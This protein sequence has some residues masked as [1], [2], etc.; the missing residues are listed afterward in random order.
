MEDK[1]AAVGRVLHKP[2]VGSVRP[3]VVVLAPAADQ[4]YRPLA[5]T[6]AHEER[7]GRSHPEGDAHQ[8]VIPTENLLMLGRRSYMA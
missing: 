1:Y 3:I 5:E 7:Q 2:A 4:Q 6:Q 8:N